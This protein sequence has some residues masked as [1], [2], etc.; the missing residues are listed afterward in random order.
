MTINE[1]QYT[2]DRN[3]FIDKSFRLLKLTR[4]AILYLSFLIFEEENERKIKREPNHVVVPM[5]SVELHDK[6]K[7]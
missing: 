7:M 5:L 4:S 3:S 6:Y 1:N 2:I